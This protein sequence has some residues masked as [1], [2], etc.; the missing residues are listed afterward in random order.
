MPMYRESHPAVLIDLVDCSQPAWVVLNGSDPKHILARAPTS[1]WRPDYYP[2]M[3]GNTSAGTV[4]NVPQ[5]S[6]LEA[7]HPVPD[8]QDTFRLYYGGSDAVVGTAVVS[9]ERVPG[10]A[11]A[12]SQ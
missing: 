5:V 2:W 11:C 4:C 8:K 12:A 6:F 7:A 3:A 1:L 10:A 9:F